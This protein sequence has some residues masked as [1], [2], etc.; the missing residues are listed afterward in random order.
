M[1]ITED[2]EKKREEGIM[3]GRIKHGKDSIRVVGVYINGDME[4]KLE[5]LREWM[6]EKE[7]GVRT[8]FGGGI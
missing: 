8:I 2:K 6:E 3:M 7:E 5:R 4:R 1:I